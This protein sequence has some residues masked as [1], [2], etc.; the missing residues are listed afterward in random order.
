MRLAVLFGDLERAAAVVPGVS[1]GT[2]DRASFLALEEALA[3]LPHQ[4]TY[5]RS[6]ADLIGDLR[7]LVGQV[8]L[9]LNLAD[10][11]YQNQLARELHVPALLELLG[12]PYTGAGPRGLVYCYDKALVK[13]VA[14]D[15]E[16]PTARGLLVPPGARVGP[17]PSGFPA[18]VK[19][20]FGDGSFGIT[21]RSVVHDEA[22]LAEAVAELRETTGYRDSILIEEYLPGPDI[23]VGAVG[24]AGHGWTIL[25]MTSVDYAA[26]PAGVPHIE[27][28]DFKWEE[29]SPYAQTRIVPASLPPEVE[30]QIRAWS[31]QL[32]DRLECR[33]YAR[34]DWR[35]D[36]QGGPRL[37]EVNPNTGWGDGGRLAEMAALAGHSYPQLL[38]LILSTARQR[39]AA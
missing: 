5:L 26:A 8:D 22:G 36:A 19:P 11:G 1:L 27:A 20:N 31:V 17:L 14:R 23:D 18:I 7:A 34:L 33:D 35:L 2:L 38:E 9:V 12:L 13:S 6:H 24:N 10:E 32:L 21:R 4:V 25:P 39:Q 30:A 37:L 16:V 29:D 15:L 28:H 3:T